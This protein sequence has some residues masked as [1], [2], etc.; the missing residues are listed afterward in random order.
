VHDIGNVSRLRKNAAAAFFAFGL[1]V[2]FSVV[3]FRSASVAAA[4]S[5]TTSHSRPNERPNEI[6]KIDLISDL[7]QRLNLALDSI[8]ILMTAILFATFTWMTTTPA[9]RLPAWLRGFRGDLIGV[10][11]FSDIFITLLISGVI[12]GVY[13]RS[14]IRCIQSRDLDAEG[15]MFFI[16]TF[17]S[18]VGAMLTVLSVV[19]SYNTLLLVQWRHLWRYH[20][21]AASVVVIIGAFAGV[22]FVSVHRLS[23]P[24]QNFV[25]RLSFPAVLSYVMI[26]AAVGSL[27]FWDPHFKADIMHVLQLSTNAA[28]AFVVFGLVTGHFLS[29]FYCK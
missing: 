21:N 27:A 7:N 13:T 19:M 6:S 2:A 26:L 1:L 25:T 10:S 5:G 8:L 24:L 14:L 29:N 17:L 4:R 9:E 28:I 22:G 16:F 12:A 15:L 3:L 23:K 11:R 18:L 20:K